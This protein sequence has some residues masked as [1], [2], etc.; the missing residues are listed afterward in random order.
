[1]LTHI[2]KFIPKTACVAKENKLANHFLNLTLLYTQTQTWRLARKRAPQIH[3]IIKTHTHTHKH[4]HT[5]KQNHTHINTHAHTH[6]HTQ[7]RTHAK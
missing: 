7:T 2:Q 5:N 4:T 1:M 3:T 6:S